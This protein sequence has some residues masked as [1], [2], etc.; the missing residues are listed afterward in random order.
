MCIFMYAGRH[1]GIYAKVN[2]VMHQ[3][4]FFSYNVMKERMH[5]SSRM[6]VYCMEGAKIMPNYRY[7]SMDVSCRN[8]CRRHPAPNPEP[9]RL[10]TDRENERVSAIAGVDHLPIA[11]A[12]VP[13]Q[14]WRKRYGEEQGFQ[15]GTIFEELDKPFCGTGGCCHGR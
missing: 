9:C 10:R 14:E 1:A 3:T 15:R 2:I 13:W 5:Q 6:S 7:H 11:M 8:G 12:Y 4:L